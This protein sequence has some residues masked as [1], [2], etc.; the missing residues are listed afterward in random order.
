MATEITWLTA[1]LDGSH[2]KDSQPTTDKLGEKFN[3]SGGHIRCLL[4]AKRLA[5]MAFCGHCNALGC[6]PADLFKCQGQL[7]I[8]FHLH[9]LHTLGN[10]SS[11]ILS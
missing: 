11:A 4:C 1:E 6:S 10:D 2:E 8:S 9:S 5:H 7:A 3:N